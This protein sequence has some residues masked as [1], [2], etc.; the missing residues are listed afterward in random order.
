MS[1]LYHTFFFDPLYNLLVLLF[2][3]LPWAD[4]GIIVIILTIIVRL[5]LYPMSRKASLTQ[6]KMA[7]ISP[8]ME[9]IKEKYKNKPEEQAR[10]TLELY[11]TEGVNPFSGILVILLQLPL[12]FALYRIFLHL[13]EVDP[14][15]I[16]SFIT[17]P[18]HVINTTFLGLVDLSAKSILIAILAGVTTYL[19]FYVMSKNQPVPKG[20]SFGDNLSRNM[21]TQAKYFLPIIMFFVTY[22]VS[23]VIGLY[24]ITTNLFGVAQEL[25]IR[26]NIKN[27]K[28]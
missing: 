4:A 11:R 21:Q 7:S 23:G 9:Q 18:S 16:Y 3:V 14:S 20:D 13:P 19:Q 6:I 10:Q 1:F 17:V 27:L 5:I 26:R 2:N 8:K 28:V 24:F 12:I 15:F 22:T 25:F